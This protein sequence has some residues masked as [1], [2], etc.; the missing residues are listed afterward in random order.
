MSAYSGRRN[1]DKKIINIAGCILIFASFIFIVKRFIALDADWKSL[2]AA[3]IFL[4]LV[5]MPFL[6]VTVIFLNSYCWGRSLSL[7]TSRQVCNGDIF[8]VYAKSNLA[9]YLPGN[10]GHYAARQMFASQI[11]VRQI[12]I[13]LASVFEIG[14]SSCSMLVL[15]LLFSGNAVAE[16]IGERFGGHKLIWF[17]ALAVIA[18][19]SLMITGYRFRKNQYV[20]EIYLLAVT[21]RFWITIF[22]SVLLFA[23]STFIIGAVF[24][25]I[26]C[27]YVP[28][29]F[30]RAFLL[31]GGCTAS[32][33]IGFITPGVPDGIGVR[34]AA[35]LLLL[36]PFFPGDKILL[37]AVIQ[38][39]TMIIGDMVVFPISR[40]FQ[41]DL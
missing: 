33:F 10:I 12:H 26:M 40:L 23:G 38:R 39:I 14:Y 22:R 25:L 41:T 2:V 16:L 37:A 17:S 20:A 11:G 4:L 6:N 27:Q 1:L 28:V 32:Y 8:A 18:V 7:F 31:I 24:V 15:S 19:A 34:E 13:A 35:M 30:E 29:D 3:P 5:T 9:K 36:E 21:P